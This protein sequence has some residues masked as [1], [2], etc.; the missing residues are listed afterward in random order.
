MKPIV[1]VMVVGVLLAGSASFAA[2]TSAKA[3]KTRAAIRQEAIDAR[4]KGE[5]TVGDDPLYPGHRATPAARPLKRKSPKTLHQDR[6]K[7]VHEDGLPEGV[8][9]T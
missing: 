1:H 9:S 8:L 7:Q 5:L 6:V 2:E 4:A 3:P